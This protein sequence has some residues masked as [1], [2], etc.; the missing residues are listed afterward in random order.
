MNALFSKRCLGKNI[1]FFV[2]LYSVICLVAYTVYGAVYDYFDIAVFL[3]M[4]FAIAA[5]FVYSLLRSDNKIVG[6]ILDFLN[7]IMAAL[8][9]IGFAVMIKNSIYVWADELN[10]IKMFGSRGG[11]APV[12]ALIAMFVVALVAEI[13]TC[14]FRDEKSE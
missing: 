14:F 2:A 6:K 5:G 4:I 12:V 10:G 3:S 8:L 9:A 7:V 13:V 11:L 1:T